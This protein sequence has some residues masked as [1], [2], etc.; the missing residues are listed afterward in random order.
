MLLIV[1]CI[2]GAAKKTSRTFT[3]VMQQSSRSESA[4]K[5]VCNEQTSSSMCRNPLLKN[6]CIR[7]D[8]NKIALHVIN[9]CLRV[10]HHLCCRSY[11]LE[12]SSRPPKQPMDRSGPQGQQQHT[13]SWF[14]EAIHRARSF[15]GDATV[16]ADYALTTTTYMHYANFTRTL[17]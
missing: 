16:L 6:F 3:Y 1:Q 10:V 5:Y 13:T 4:D 8:T 11:M 9:Q 2:P 12:S 7:C 17:Q 14:V 15:G